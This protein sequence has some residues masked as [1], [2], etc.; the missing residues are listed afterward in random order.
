MLTSVVTRE[1]K[2]LVGVRVTKAQREQIARVVESTGLEQSDLLRLVIA[3]GLHG[4]EDV[5]KPAPMPQD[6]IMVL[7][8]R[9]A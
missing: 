8:A 3:R 9:N 6:E 7:A 4:I 1:P 2:P 5:V